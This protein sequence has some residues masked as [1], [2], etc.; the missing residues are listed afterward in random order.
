MSLNRTA[1][2][3]TA[4]VHAGS[5]IALPRHG[6]PCAVPY[7]IPDDVPSMRDFVNEDGAISQRL[8]AAWV[9]LRV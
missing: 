6:V 1:S 8:G 2:G 9:V 3:S 4:P 7:G 5:G